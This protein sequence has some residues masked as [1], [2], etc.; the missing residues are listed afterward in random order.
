MS[1]ATQAFSIFRNDQTFAG[2]VHLRVDAAQAVAG[3]IAT[4]TA[5]PTTG[6]K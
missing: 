3:A 2:G 4:I 6:I 1:I 5:A